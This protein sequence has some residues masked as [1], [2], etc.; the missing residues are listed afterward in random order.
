MVRSLDLGRT[1]VPENV[2]NSTFPAFF[3]F[4]CLY[5]HMGGEPVRIPVKIAAA[6]AES[7]G[8]TRKI[9]VQ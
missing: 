3:L 8:N 2:G 5:A 1:G 4:F 9:A 6:F 7:T